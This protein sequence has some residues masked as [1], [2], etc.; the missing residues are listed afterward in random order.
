LFSVAE[1][2]R[3][4]AMIAVTGFMSDAYLVMATSQGEVKR[5]A[6]GK[7]ASVRSSGLITMDLEA[8]DELVAACSAADQD[9]VIL[10]TKKGKSIK[11][12]V[13]GIRASSRTSGGVRAIRLASG[14]SVVSMDTAATDAFLLVV[15]EG[16]LGKLTLVAQ[17]PRQHRGGMGV[18][19]FNIVE[20]AGDVTA[21][22][23]VSRSDQVMIISAEGIVERIHI[24][25]ISVQGRSTQG[26]KLMSLDAGDKVVA[27][28][29]FG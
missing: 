17:Y 2:E 11:F 3:V 28:A 5:T 19:T 22:E 8:G 1:N 6:V 24:K 20:K 23:V 26:V 16:G 12:G 13:T 27:I 9:D 18:R 21:A 4:T 25:D 29:A 10:V 15:A 7:F 14:D